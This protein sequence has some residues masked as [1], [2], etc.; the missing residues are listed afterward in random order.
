[1]SID[2]LISGGR[3][4]DGTGNPWRYADVAIGGDRI[5]DVAPPGRI[6]P[7]QAREV[8]LSDP[9]RAKAILNDPI[10]SGRASPEEVELMWNLCRTDKQCR[11]FM[12]ER[13]HK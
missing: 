12:R 6:S 3:V 9:S 10:Y 7:E 11:D 1:M 4:V 8:M 5:V 13:Y 2:I